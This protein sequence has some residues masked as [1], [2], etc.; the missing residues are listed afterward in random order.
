MAV[1]R[2]ADH[3]P[4]TNARLH[5]SMRDI[6]TSQRLNERNSLTPG[7]WIAIATIAVGILGGVISVA[8]G[9]HNTRIGNIETA[10]RTMTE[11]QTRMAEAQIRMA[12]ALTRA[13][14]N[15]KATVV[16]QF[17]SGDSGARPAD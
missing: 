1:K 6:V 11:A 10:M 4:P 3:S 14:G 13:D 17:H 12:E 7:H 15:A 9:E 16:S 2:I 5:G 8:L